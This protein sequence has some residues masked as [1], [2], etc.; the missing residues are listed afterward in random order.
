MINSLAT[1]LQPRLAQFTTDPAEDH[2]ASPAPAL[3]L[4]RTIALGLVA[5]LSMAVGSLY[6]GI[7]FETHLPGAWFFGMPGGLL[8]SIGSD[9][10]RPPLLAVFAVF[11]GLIL[12]TRVW[13][14]LLRHL[15]HHHGVPIRKVILVVAIWAVPFMLAPPLFSGDV[16]SYAGQGE[17]VSHHINP[18]D[19]GTGVLGSTPFSSM[20]ASVWSNSPSPYGPTFLA[21]DGALTAASG[22]KILPDIMLLRLLEL[23]GLA[24]I[25]AATPSLARALGRDPAEAILLGAGSPLALTTLISG[26]H[27]DAL[28]IGLLMAGLALA[29]RFGA[30]PGIVL[31]A[32][33]AGVKAPALLGVVFLG[34]WWAGPGASVR[35]RVGHTL[36]ALLIA[37]CTFEIITVITGLGWGWVRNSTVADHAFT[38]VTPIGAV[39]RLV[40]LT[41]QGV[42]VPVSAVSV[43]SVLAIFGLIVAGIIGAW[44]LWR[45]PRDGVT[46]NL[47]LSLL[48]LA[49]LSP[50]LWAWYTLWGILVL[51]PVASGRLRAAIITIATVEAFVG[52]TSVRSLLLGV[53]H[54]GVIPDL[55]LIA[56]LVAIS[57]V[58]FN[59]L[60]A[61]R[62]RHHPAA[63]EAGRPMATLQ[64]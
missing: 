38:F 8:G 12:L 51:A 23:A 57:I 64:S 3:R 21:F 54:A 56:A 9:S 10:T 28:M 55:I 16:Y 7:T 48:V 39:S 1:R 22:H 45:S 6:G 53:W 26:A 11:G 44:L 42:N 13:I 4:G 60:H 46:R 33:A 35:R 20:P 25:V 58:P 43:R 15:R 29:R 2:V 49:L 37:L 17:M 5:T 32:V 41:S 61:S 62:R 14:G 31:C 19:Y 18:Y 36:G 30:L 40:S 50:I 47:G 52:V 34:W 24:L 63:P 59:Q 27:N